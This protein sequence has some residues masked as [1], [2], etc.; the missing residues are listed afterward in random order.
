[1]NA[2]TTAERTLR[3][4]RITVGVLAV[5]AA[6]VYLTLK[7]LWVFGSSL[8]LADIR[9]AE[10]DE[11]VAVNAATAV[12]GLAGVLVALAL[13]QRWG[14]RVPAWLIAPPMWVAT[15]LLT[16]IALTFPFTGLGADE[17][18][19]GL[20]PWVF[21]VVYSSFSVLG[22]TLAVSIVLYARVRWAVFFH[23]RANEG[24]PGATHSV[25]VP[26]AWTGAVLAAAVALLLSWWTVGGTTGLDPAEL[27]AVPG[28]VPIGNG[29]SAVLAFGGAGGLLTLMHRWSRM[30]YWMPL[31]C[32]WVGAGYLFADGLLAMPNVLAEPAWT[33]FAQTPAVAGTL[34]MLKLCA[35]LLLGIVA[36]M[37]LSERRATESVATQ[38]VV[39]PS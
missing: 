26:L 4:L 6:S 23:G 33:P 7:V 2:M 19:G 17:P 24:V 5:A 38:G 3:P 32:A 25:Q 10:T 1:M 13:T 22:A 9:L 8:G 16:P 21:T 37:L 20:Q 15:G 14:L 39:P 18:S 28:W 34:S 11:W 35:G 36:L 12:L 30:P 31:V 27:P 29:I